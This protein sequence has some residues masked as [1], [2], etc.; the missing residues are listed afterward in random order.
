MFLN[1]LNSPFASPPQVKEQMATH[2]GKQCNNYA[3]WKVMYDTIMA[4]EDDTAATVSAIEKLEHE[5]MQKETHN[6]IPWN[7]NATSTASNQ[8]PIPELC[9]AE[10]KIMVSVAE[11]KA[12][13]WINGSAPTLEDL[14]NPI[15]EWQVSELQYDFVGGDAEI[16]KEAR[17]QINGPETIE[18]EDSDGSSDEEVRISNCWGAELCEQLERGCITHSDIIGS[19]CDWLAMAIV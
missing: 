14:L 5:A 6:E 8:P 4:A 2:L 13:K 11:L 17:R 18:V 12:W 3:H 10:A 1:S 16:V 7:T 9:K 15:E 19:K